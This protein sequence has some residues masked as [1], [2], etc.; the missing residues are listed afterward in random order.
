[1]LLLTK[2]IT[3]IAAMMMMM[4]IYI[5]IIFSKAREQE[6]ERQQGRKKESCVRGQFVRFIPRTFSSCCS[7][8]VLPKRHVLLSESRAMGIIP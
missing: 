6:H 8:R 1:M 2:I 5:F 7:S 4:R 3:M